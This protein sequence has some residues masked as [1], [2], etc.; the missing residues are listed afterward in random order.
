MI[1]FHLICKSKKYYEEANLTIRLRDG[2]KRD[3]SYTSDI[4]IIPA[5]FDFKGQGYPLKETKENPERLQVND[6][7]NQ[8]IDIIKIQYKETKHLNL[9]NKDFKCLLNKV[10]SQKEESRNKLHSTFGEEFDKFIENLYTTDE[11]REAFRSVSR[12]FHRFQYYK[13]AI[14]GQRQSSY[15]YCD[16]NAEVLNEFRMYLHQEHKLYSQFPE[17]YKTLSKKKIEFRKKNTIIGIFRKMHSFS[18]KFKLMYRLDYDPFWAFKIGSE[19]YEEPIP[20]TDEEYEYLQ[21]NIVKDPE[22]QIIQKMFLLQTFFGIRY[23]DYINAKKVDIVNGSLIAYPKKT[24]ELKRKVSIPL[25]EFGAEIIGD[26]YDETSETTYLVPRYT[27][28]EYNIKLKELFKTLGLNRMISRFD[29]EKG[30]MVHR[31]LHEIVSSHFARRTFINTLFN[32]GFDTLTIKNM[33]GMSENSREI[34]RYYKLNEKNK[35]LCTNSLDKRKSTSNTPIYQISSFQQ[36][37]AN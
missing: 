34:A 2:G 31:P 23:V 8:V 36:T 17:Q 9:T 21:N 6:R 15:R 10:I 28:D 37:M 18:N 29:E 11:R 3:Y 22:L 4:R 27:L 1:K 7:I 24:I 5:I 25:N 13:S 12:S 16:I 26:F 14:L 35:Q 20:L 30:E 19:K 33:A 32:E